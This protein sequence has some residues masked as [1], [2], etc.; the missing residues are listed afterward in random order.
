MDGCLHV[1]VSVCSSDFR[2]SRDSFYF[3]FCSTC[4]DDDPSLL[5]GSKIISSLVEDHRQNIIVDYRCSFLFALGLSLFGLVA[6]S[7]ADTDFQFF[8]FEE[9]L[10]SS[11]H[12]DD[13][14]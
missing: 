1:C 6:L 13:H 9:T 10:F 2:F 8:D 3:L 12:A 5:V 14:H 11:S 4:V 7:E